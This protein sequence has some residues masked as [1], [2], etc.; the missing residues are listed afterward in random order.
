[1]IA[2]AQQ[3]ETA[4]ASEL[5]MRLWVDGPTRQPEQVTRRFASMPP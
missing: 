1:M 3:G 5:Q 4:L 2:A